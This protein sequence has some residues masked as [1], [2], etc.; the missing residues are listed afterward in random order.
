[1]SDMNVQRNAQTIPTDRAGKAS[2]SQNV[3]KAADTTQQGVGNAAYK[4]ALRQAPP[5]K[6]RNPPPASAP[7]IIPPPGGGN[8]GAKIPNADIP[9]VAMGNV[10]VQLIELLAEFASKNSKLQQA[11]TKMVGKAFKSMSDRGKQEVVAIIDSAT[12]DKNAAYAAMAGSV[13]QL[14]ATAGTFGASKAMEGKKM[15]AG[16]KD[17]L[18]KS[19]KDFKSG[20]LQSLKES[21]MPGGKTGMKA[22]SERITDNQNKLEV[23]AKANTTEKLSNDADQASITAD[24]EASQKDPTIT[25]EAKKKAEVGFKKRQDTLDAKVLAN[26]KE[27]AEIAGDQKLLGKI[28]SLLSER[29]SKISGR[30]TQT[31]QAITQGAQALGTTTDTSGRIATSDEKTDA[32][33]RKAALSTAGQIDSQR[34]AQT[35]STAS[36]VGQD[37]A[38]MYE[39]QSALTS[40]NAADSKG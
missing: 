15:D 29:E 4:S 14:T 19:E 26:K 28:G 32:E 13:I 7:T 25:R 20:G 33:A 21:E 5:N 17:V 6:N 12:A 27:G 18:G 36:S 22:A 40:K 2:Q 9:F 31:T 37:V 24:R 34:L 16:A 39:K 38:S 8:S 30:T 1:M 23:K 11:E 10:M 3:T 35:M